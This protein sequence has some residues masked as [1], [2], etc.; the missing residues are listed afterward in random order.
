MSLS[1]P[2][3]KSSSSVRGRS[4]WAAMETSLGGWYVLEVSQIVDVVSLI[5]LNRRDILCIVYSSS[6]MG[7]LNNVSYTLF[8]VGVLS[9]ISID[10]GLVEIRSK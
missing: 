8:P 3:N 1:G 7:S 5:I 10:S 4:H 9:D 2:G 6:T